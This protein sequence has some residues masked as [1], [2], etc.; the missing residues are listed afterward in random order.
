VVHINAQSNDLDG[1]LQFSPTKRRLHPIVRE[2]VLE[3]A[4]TP[5]HD[6][7]YFVNQTHVTQ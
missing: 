3:P 5:S 7:V 1:P 2:K 6:L 4:S